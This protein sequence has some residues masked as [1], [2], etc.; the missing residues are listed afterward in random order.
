MKQCLAELN[1]AVSLF[2]R[3]LSISLLPQTYIFSEHPDRRLVMDGKLCSHEIQRSI[4]HAEI[5]KHHCLWHHLECTVMD[6]NN[7]KVLTNDNEK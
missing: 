1:D 2:S 7:T 4:S 5:L 3:L 6:E